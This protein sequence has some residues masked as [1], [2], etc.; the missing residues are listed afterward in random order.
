MTAE[1]DDH[2]TRIDDALNR[3]NR[4]RRDDVAALAD[5]VRRRRMGDKVTV[6]P[7]VVSCALRYALPRSTYITGLMAGVVRSTWSQLG[8]QQAVVRKDIVEHLLHWDRW[9]KDQPSAALHE[10]DIR[11][12]RELLAWIDR[13][14]GQ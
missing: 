13:Q 10:I 12:W 2:V 6:D 1:L 11:V 9:G 8:D 5:E 14:D 4:F 3:G 7:V